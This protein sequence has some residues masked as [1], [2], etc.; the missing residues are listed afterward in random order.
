M[1]C[2]FIDLKTGNVTTQGY[3]S[4]ASSVDTALLVAGALTAGQYFKGRV[5]EMA[6][7]LYA[8]VDWASF[9]NP[10]NGQVY[11][12]WFPSEKGNMN[13]PG[14][15][16]RQTWDWYTSETMLT[17]MLG[18]AAPNPAYRLP[19]QSL[20]NW[21]RQSGRGADGEE[22]IVSWTGGFFTY[23]FAQCY[24]DFRRTGKDPLGVDWFENTRRA[25]RAN[26][27][28]CRAQA[29]RFA[30][31]GQDRWGITSGAGPNKTYVVPGHQPRGAA[32]D[33][34]EGGTLQP[35]GAGM[36]LPYLP[37]DSIAA[38]RHMRTLEV[39]GQPVWV[40]P[41]QGGYGFMDGFNIERGWVADH[42]IGIADGPML[43]MIENARTG[44]VWDLFMAHPLIKAGITRAGFTG[45]TE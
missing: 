32:G 38:L 34:P 31:Y 41:A 28:W 39:G 24:Y 16:D 2:H 27:D 29:G 17:V 30:T 22:F 20:T 18:I 37:D 21:K 9:V 26:R 11:M 7:Q 15:F 10:Q 3:E 42:V 45:K 36:A 1:F 14:K 8:Q 4:G 12:I 23:I 5:Q 6:D 19:P 35:Y 13:G 44:L 25:A 43:L 40:D 33:S